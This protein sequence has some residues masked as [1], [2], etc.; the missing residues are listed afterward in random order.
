MLREQQQKDLDA[1]IQQ[2]DAAA[3]AHAQQHGNGN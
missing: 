1:L 2:R 3:K